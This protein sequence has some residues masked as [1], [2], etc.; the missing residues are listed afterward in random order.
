MDFV[1]IGQKFDKFKENC[2]RV[3]QKLAK[4][5]HKKPDLAWQ[6]LYKSVIWQGIP[7]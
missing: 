7:N 6:S 1:Q 2:A 3:D 4:F 5:L